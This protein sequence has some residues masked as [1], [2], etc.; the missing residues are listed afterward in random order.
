MPPSP[1]HVAAERLAGVALHVARWSERTLAEH[2]PPLTVAQFLVLDALA[3]GARTPG[4]L[5]ARAAVSDAA[6]SQLL[7]DL[8]AGGL[9]T[10]A[11]SPLDRRRHELALTDA[12]R[13][14]RAAAWRL[15]AARLAGVLGDLPD[16][17]ARQLGEL[18]G[19]IGSTI[20]RVP[21]PPRPRPTAPPPHPRPPT[22]GRRG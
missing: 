18:L 17:E 2:E 19:R 4:E 5:A 21:P 22:P 20:A 13:Q 7:R 9:V 3:D 8:E 1:K 14:T 11:L 16:A 10:R 15:V 12:G 6:V